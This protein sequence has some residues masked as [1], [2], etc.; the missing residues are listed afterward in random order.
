MGKFFYFTLFKKNGF[1]FL[2][3][4]CVIYRN[5]FLEFIILVT[6]S[7]I[8]FYL[9][10]YFIY[11]LLFIRKLLR[12]TKRLLYRN[13]L[14]FILILFVIFINQFLNKLFNSKKKNGIFR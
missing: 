6:K 12:I 7:L 1:L 4:C 14:S 13:S 9:I 11:M 8:A 10:V 3:A 5:H 2:L